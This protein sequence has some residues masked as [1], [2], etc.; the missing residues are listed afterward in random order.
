MQQVSFNVG[1]GSLSGSGGSLT[2]AVRLAGSGRLATAGAG[3]LGGS[4]GASA[5]NT[6]VVPGGAIPWITDTAHNRWTITA[7]GQVA[8]NGLT[9]SSTRNVIELAWVKGVIWQ[10]NT[11][12]NWYSKTSTSAPWTVGTKVSPLP[13]ARL[14]GT[15]RGW[16]S[17]LAAIS[18][19][20]IL[21]GRGF[22]DSF[23]IAF[24]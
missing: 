11:A 13:S 7:G 9:D 6:V 14:L 17:A 4:S 2:T 3:V 24:G 5:D 12:G 23:S 21:Q 10:R 20:I 16:D 18:S 22:S 8:V 15:G 1:I 19:G